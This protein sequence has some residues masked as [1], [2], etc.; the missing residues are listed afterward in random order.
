MLK[1]SIVIQNDDSLKF[2]EQVKHELTKYKLQDYV[3]EIQ[4]SFGSDT[5]T[6]LLLVSDKE[7]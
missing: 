1:Y 2:A 4:Y 6:A 5:Y 3:C 7:G